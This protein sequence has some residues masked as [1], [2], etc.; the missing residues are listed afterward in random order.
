M[1]LAIKVLTLTMMVRLLIVTGKPLLSAVIYG[2][3]ALILGAGFGEE[4]ASAE[5]MATLGFVA[6][7]VYFWI[8]SRLDEGSFAWW[9]VAIPGVALVFL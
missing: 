8:L 6:A 9:F 1:D 4:L 5:L 3:V 7:F 2:V